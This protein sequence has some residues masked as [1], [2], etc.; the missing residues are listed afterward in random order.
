MMKGN[1]KAGIFGFFIFIIFLFFAFIGGFMSGQ[2][3]DSDSLV[4]DFI[5]SKPDL[6][7][8]VGQNIQE[9]FLYTCRGSVSLYNYCLQREGGDLTA[10]QTCQSRFST[11]IVDNCQ[12]SNSFCSDRNF[13]IC[14]T[15]VN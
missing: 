6:F 8:G 3:S 4:S 1:K 15:E 14:L 5:G 2:N 10:I 11:I 7:S 12:A 9:E 13:A